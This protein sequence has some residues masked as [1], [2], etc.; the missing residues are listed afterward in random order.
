MQIRH[1]VIADLPSIVAIYN[2]SIP[3]GMATADTQPVKVT[4]RQQWFGNHDPNRYPLWVAVEDRRVTGWLGLSAFYDRPAWNPTVE[5][6]LYVHPDHQRRGTGRSLVTHAIECAPP[7]GISTILALV[8]A[9]NR[10]SLDLLQAQGFA[11]WGLLPRS[12]HMP[13]GRRDVVLLG[14]EIS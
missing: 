2:A 4:D 11:Q 10:P 7:L 6:S 1:A 12:A 8:F 14:L 3:G 13:E 9:H 5:L